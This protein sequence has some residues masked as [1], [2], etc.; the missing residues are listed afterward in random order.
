MTVTAGVA[1]MSER[2]FGAFWKDLGEQ[3][4]QLIRDG[5]E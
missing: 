4:E 2:S 3:L 1:C 5:M